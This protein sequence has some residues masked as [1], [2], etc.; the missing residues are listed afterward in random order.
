M[1]QQNFK[2]RITLRTASGTIVVEVKDI[3]Y[4]KGD[5]NYSQLV[6]FY[7][8]DTVL[9]GLGALEKIL[10]PEVFVRAD[11]STLINIHHIYSLLPKQR[12]CIFRSQDGKEIETTLREPAFR[13]LQNLL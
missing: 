3:A 6:T 11:R 8:Q 5:G 4:F 10:S 9:T 1:T 12:R 2:Q 7:N 13:R